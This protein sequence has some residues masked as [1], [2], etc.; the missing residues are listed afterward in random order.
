MRAP[1]EWRDLKGRLDAGDGYSLDPSME[2]GVIMFLPPM[3]FFSSCVPF[4]YSPPELLDTRSDRY[5]YVVCSSM[6]ERHTA[7][8]NVAT[9]QASHYRLYS[10]GGFGY[11]EYLHVCVKH[12]VGTPA[13][14]RF[15]SQI[16]IWVTENADFD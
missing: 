16:C 8:E 12:L 9:A 2:V 7:W 15:M 13:P 3:L 4:V 1:R 10:R 5:M 6:L 14:V 11:R